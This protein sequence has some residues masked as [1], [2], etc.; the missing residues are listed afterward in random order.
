MRHEQNLNAGTPIAR[1]CVILQSTTFKYYTSTSIQNVLIARPKHT[2]L[3]MRSSTFTRPK[4]TKPLSAIRYNRPM[5]S[6][7]STSALRTESTTLMPL[8]SLCSL[9]LVP[10]TVIL[11]CGR[12]NGSSVWH[13][14]TP[15]CRCGAAPVTTSRVLL[16]LGLVCSSTVYF[17]AAPL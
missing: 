7:A 14:S 10:V 12:H 5:S 16:G 2:H 11:T 13:C 8:S 6:T 15:T 17:A 4:R 9:E 1:V 3:Q